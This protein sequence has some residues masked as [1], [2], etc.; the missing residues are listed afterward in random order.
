MRMMYKYKKVLIGV[1]VL[2]G[3][4]NLNFKF[5]FKGFLTAALTRMHI[6]LS[7]LQK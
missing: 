2:L 6:L 3:N 5:K 4:L 7:F 1:N